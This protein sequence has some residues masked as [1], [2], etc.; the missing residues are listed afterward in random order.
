MTSIYLEAIVPLTMLSPSK[1]RK[2]RTTR[3]ET[4]NKLRLAID[5]ADVTQIQVAE[6]VGVAQS[7]VSEDANGKYSELSLD[8]AR[9]YAEFFGCDVDDLFPRAEQVAS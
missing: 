3:T 1:L 9:D 2:L 6:A 4:P 8:K 5:L 7:Q